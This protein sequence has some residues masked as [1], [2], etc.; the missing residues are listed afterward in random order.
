MKRTLF[1]ALGLILH[2]LA[3]NNAAY[4][5]D[6]ADRSQIGAAIDDDHADL[7]GVFSSSGG[8]A[9]AQA[10]SATKA[11]IV[12][13]YVPACQGNL[14]QSRRNLGT[15]CA[16]AS[17]LCASTPNPDDV[18]YWVYTAPAG[19]PDPGPADWTSTGQVVCRG[20]SEPADAVEP[21]VT[22]ADFRRLPL[23][24]AGLKV[25]PP[26][27]QTLVNIP[28]NLYADSR[29]AVLPTRILGFAVRVRATPLRFRWIYGDGTDLRTASAGGPYPRLDTAH[30]YRQPGS[31]TVRLST[32]YAGEYSVTGGP[33]LPID[34]V[35]TVASPPTT[36]TVRAAENQL[37]AEPLS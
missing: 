24:A 11:R 5:A 35:A 36:L 33:W 19:P 32:T 17:G 6:P 15:L 3:M 22:A 13:T 26:T 21:V 2:S 37:V 28:T 18:G 9:R 27:R 30:T 31:R 8:H 4:A 10:A 7:T 34:G 20:P 16:Q 12:R 25:Q 29:A 23:P 1:V 14:P